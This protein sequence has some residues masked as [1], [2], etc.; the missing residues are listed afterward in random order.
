M[1]ANPSRDQVKATNSQIAPAATIT[2]AVNADAM[3]RY[4]V[5]TT[6]IVSGPDGSIDDGCVI[7][8]AGRRVERTERV[9]AVARTMRSH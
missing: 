7:T 4:R 6:R 5:C 2:S 8:A 1:T 9:L 3:R